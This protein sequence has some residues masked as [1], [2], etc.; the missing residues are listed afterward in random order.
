M[1]FKEMRIADLAVIYNTD[2]FSKKAIYK[3]NKIA[4]FEPKDEIDVF[5]VSLKKFKGLESDFLEIKE[6]D[7]IEIE[8]VLYEI[9]NFSEPKDFQRIFSVKESNQ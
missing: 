4:V 6:G 1:T 3:E 5:D 8:G 2:E 7:E 9:T